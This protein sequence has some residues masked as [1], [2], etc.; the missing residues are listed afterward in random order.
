MKTRLLGWLVA[1]ATVAWAPMASA[2]SLFLTADPSAVAPGGQIRIGVGVDDAASLSS[3]QFSLQFDAAVVQPGSPTFST[4]GTLIDPAG[5]NLAD[6]S[7]P[8]TVDVTPSVGLIDVFAESLEGLKSTTGSG[9][10][11]Y[12]LFDVPSTASA[13]GTADFIVGDTLLGFNL[14]DPDSSAV[15]DVSDARATVSI[16]TTGN[17]VPEPAG[18][19]LG[20]LAL[21]LAAGAR[22]RRVVTP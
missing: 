20:A 17:P 3:F 21:A 16:R 15:P 12:L 2:Y 8:F 5:S 1:L 22:R 19:A 7:F 6:A 18:I 9:V 11:L 14:A 4:T 10:L 13:P